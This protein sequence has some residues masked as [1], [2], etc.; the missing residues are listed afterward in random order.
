MP[1]ALIPPPRV[2]LT[3]DDRALQR[4]MHDFAQLKIKSDATVVNKAMRF[5]VPF[6]A[7]KVKDKTPFPSRLRR[8]LMAKTGKVPPKTKTRVKSPFSTAAGPSLSGHPLA[9]TVVASILAGQLAKKHG[10]VAASGM[11]AQ[12]FYAK[13]ERMLGAKVGSVN[14]LRAG[15]IPIYRALK[16]PPKF[17]PKNHS[18]FA[19][20]SIGVVAKPSP[21]RQA[22]SWVKNEREGTSVIAPNAFRDS[23][24]E[25]TRMFRR[26]IH[27]DT[28]ALARQ[29]G[30]QVTT[31]P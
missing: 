23:V 4:A 22:E 11:S 9:R 29:T 28:L 15:F 30:F 6:A 1:P 20:R 31:A 24:P 17:A 2:A 8:K 13:A 19:G 21:F 25:V 10:S 27:E 18:R 7:R 3:F 12:E 26:W 5:W 14:Y 16:V